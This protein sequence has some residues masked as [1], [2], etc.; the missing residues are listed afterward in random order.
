MTFLE[1]LDL[2]NPFLTSKDIEEIIENDCP[3]D[4]G[5]EVDQDSCCCDC[6]ACWNRKI[7][8]K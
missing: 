1:R 2:Y 3:C 6:K 5:F 8:G 4:Y 7:G